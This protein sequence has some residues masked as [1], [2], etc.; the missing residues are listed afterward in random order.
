MVTRL[1]SANLPSQLRGIWAQAQYLPDAMRG[2]LTVTLFS[3]P[4]DATPEKVLID[5]FA[6][7]GYLPGEAKQAALKILPKKALDVR[8]ELTER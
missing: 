3:A 1:T 6:R 2:A 7:L 8:P 4:D 5:T